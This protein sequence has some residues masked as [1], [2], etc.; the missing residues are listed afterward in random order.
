MAGFT[1]AFGIALM[2]F[3]TASRV[4]MF[5]STAAFAAVEVVFIGSVSA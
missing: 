2:F 4:E 5:S 3:T 1:T